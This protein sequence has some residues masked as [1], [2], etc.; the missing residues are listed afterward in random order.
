MCVGS[1]KK[2]L[3]RTSTPSILIRTKSLSYGATGGVGTTRVYV[4]MVTL[5]TWTA[6]A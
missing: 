2:R 5:E 4:E 3:T 6:G 1:K